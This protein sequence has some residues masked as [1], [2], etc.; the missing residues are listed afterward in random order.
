MRFDGR[1]SIRWKVVIPFFMMTVLVVAV[2]LPITTALV[3]RRTEAEADR[4]L[5]EIAESVAAL[6]KSSEGKALLSANFVA[7][8]SEVEAA[9]SDKDL[10]RLALAPLKEELGLQELSYYAP[11]FQP[12]EP[13]LYYGGPLV[14]RFLQVSGH[15]NRIRDALILQALET[16]EATSGIAIAPQAS[17]I[18]GVS[19]VRSNQGSRNAIK[20]VILTAFYLDE[21][22]IADI[23]EVLDADVA[24]VK[25]NAVIASTI[26]RVSGYELHLQKGFVDPNGGITA[27]YLEY[28][29]DIQQRLLAHPLILDG[30]QQGAVLVAQSINNLLQVRQDIQVALFIFAIG[31]GVVSVLMGLA[32]LLTFARPLS[33]L[34]EATNRISG[35]ALEQRVNAPYFL[36]R[37]EVTELSDN[38]NSMTERLQDL[39]L[40]L[41]Q[42]VREQER[43][44]HELR[45]ARRIQQLLLP[46][47]VP[48]LAGWQM[49]ASYLPARSVGGDFYDF[50]ELPDG[51]LGLIIGDATD[52]GMPAALIMATTRSTLRATASRLVS[53]GHSLERVNE[54]LCP[55]FPPNMFVTCLYAV[56]DPSN[57]RI[58]YANAGHNLPYRRTSGG[59][60]ELRATGMPLGLMP[61]MGYEEQETTLDPG[62]S[63][64]LYS[65]GLVEAHNPEREMFSSPRLQTLMLEHRGGPALIDFLLTE[66][67]AFTGSNWEQEDDVT[68]VSLQ[69]SAAIQ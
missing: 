16:G 65:D 68:L 37:D 21:A 5:S 53:P 13:A 7:N 11:G 14:A 60:A 10:I 36:F 46:K 58:Q 9:D 20:G 69:R 44:E 1:M 49:A 28:G 47:E 6:I 38:F 34:A 33:A 56:L 50:L 12:G 26:D 51:R 48:A 8:L 19:P 3:A 66:L 43:T 17:Q 24:V 35:G 57:G 41:E 54:L 31:I 61:E 30:E 40:S 39:Y 29:E 59:V 27:R 55:E 64:L 32:A 4:R 67:A 62:E 45:V 22:F 42:R 2:L 23:S 52:K 15:A 63:L 18:I 25:D